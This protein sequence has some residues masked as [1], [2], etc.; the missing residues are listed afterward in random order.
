M[1]ERVPERVCVLDG[2]T[3]GVP[4]IVLLELEVGV[5]VL[6]GVTVPVMEGVTVGVLVILE[7]D[8]GVCDGV[9]GPV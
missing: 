7:P 8:E 4:L 9:T 1:L 5:L 3:D 2:V 6:L